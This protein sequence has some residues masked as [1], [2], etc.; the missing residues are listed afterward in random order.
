MEQ[1]KTYFMGLSPVE[2]D[3]FAG[4]CETSRRHLTNIAYGKTCG[5]SLAICIERESKGAVRCEE[6]R[7]DVDWAY[8]RGTDC[9]PKEAA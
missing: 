2:R 5:E 8:L 6:L 1:F 4:R 7:P 3:Q 9:P